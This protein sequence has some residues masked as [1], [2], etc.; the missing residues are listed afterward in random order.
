[1]PPSAPSCDPAALPRHALLVLQPQPEDTELE[2]AMRTVAQRCEAH[3]APC[4]LFGVQLVVES[5]TQRRVA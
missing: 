3:L 1:M 4:E 5:D 2:E